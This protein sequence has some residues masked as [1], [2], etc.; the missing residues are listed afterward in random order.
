MS[1]S[2][3]QTRLQAGADTS[4]SLCLAAGGVRRPAMHAEGSEPE[5]W[6]PAQ[7]VLQDPHLLHLILQHLDVVDM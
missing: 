2:R 6:Q 5:G 7:A 1:P 3:M 4:G